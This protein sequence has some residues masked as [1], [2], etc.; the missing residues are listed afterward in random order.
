MTPRNNKATALLLAAT[1]LP[2]PLAKAPTLPEPILA[3][4]ELLLAQMLPA[5]LPVRPPIRRQVATTPLISSLLKH[6][7]LKSPRLH[8]S[9]LRP[10][11]PQL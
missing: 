9:Y 5:P 4:P 1:L 8:L 11:L 3:P 7:L 2:L 6:R 10:P